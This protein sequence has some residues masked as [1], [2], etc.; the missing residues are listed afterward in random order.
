MPRLPYLPEFSFSIKE[1]NIRSVADEID[2]GDGSN[3]GKSFMSIRFDFS[4]DFQQEP[5]SLVSH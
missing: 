1:Y 5:V 4:I 3:Y 2:S